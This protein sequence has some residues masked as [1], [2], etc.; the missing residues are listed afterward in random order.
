MN[1]YDYVIVDAGSAGCV[2]APRLG[3][4]PVTRILVLEAGPPDD[5]PEMCVP[6]ATRTLYL[7]RSANVDHEVSGATRRRHAGNPVANF[8]INVG[9]RFPSVPQRH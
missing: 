1:E 7:G 3:A 2:L 8:M 9:K 4:D 5:A 6:A